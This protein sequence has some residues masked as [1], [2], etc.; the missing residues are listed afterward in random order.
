MKEII[1]GY[2]SAMSKSPPNFIIFLFFI[3]LFFTYIIYF[4]Y[5]I[6]H[7]NKFGIKYSTFFILLYLIFYFIIYKHGFT[8]DNG[9]Y[10]FQFQSI[11]LGFISIYPF[12]RNKRVLIY[13]LPIFF[14]LVFYIVR[15]DQEFSKSTKNKFGDNIVL[16]LKNYNFYMYSLKNIPYFFFKNIIINFKI[17]SNSLNQFNYSTNLNLYSKSLKEINDTLF[18]NKLD[19]NTDIYPFDITFLTSSKNSWNPRPVFQSYSSYT[20]KLIEDNF[21]HIN[22]T[23]APDNILFR[24]QTIDNRLPSIDD[25]VSWLAI[26]EKYDLIKMKSG[27]LYFKK[28]K[29][30]TKNHIIK[31]KTLKYKFNQPIINNFS[32]NEIIFAK[33]E[34]NNNFLGDI[35]NFIYKPQEFYI[36]YYFQDKTIKKYRI[37]PNMLKNGVCIYPFVSNTESFLKLIDINSIKNKAVY[38]IKIIPENKY[39]VNSSFELKMQ[40]LINTN[41]KK[42]SLTDSVNFY[43]KIPLI[44]WK[45]NETLTTSLN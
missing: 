2:P 28:K 36:E 4:F 6:Y 43:N 5:I 42:I 10:V 31:Y 44:W 14:L 1:K 21:N 19:G 37:I 27:L 38:S 25:G 16:N 30:Y 22:N 20:P 12:Y 34:I 11:L 23:N 33:I 13:L 45:P 40:K 7:N 17:K 39:L 8:R 41:S 29:T 3:L 24:I 9:I 18:I 35:Y 32:N 26:L 15:Y